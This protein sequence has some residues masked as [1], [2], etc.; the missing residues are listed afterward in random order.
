[1]SLGPYDKGRS[2][3]NKLHRLTNEMN[4]TIDKARE[5]WDSNINDQLDGLEE[6]TDEFKRRIKKLCRETGTSTDDS[7]YFY[8]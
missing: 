7:Y 8:R 2:M 4:E 6:L 5:D 3:I 1:M